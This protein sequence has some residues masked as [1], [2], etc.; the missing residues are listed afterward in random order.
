MRMPQVSLHAQ[1]SYQSGRHLKEPRTG[2]TQDLAQEGGLGL[3]CALGIHLPAGS[4][5]M[6]MQMCT[7]Q[8]EG[9]PLSPPG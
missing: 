8:A 3:T 9:T 6:S 1:A 4:S 7:A 2:E 5:E